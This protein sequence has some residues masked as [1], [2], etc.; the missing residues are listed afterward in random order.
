MACAAEWVAWEAA[1][2]CSSKATE[3]QKTLKN[4]QEKLRYIIQKFDIGDVYKAISNIYNDCNKFPIVDDTYYDEIDS[5]LKNEMLDVIKLMG[6]FNTI[7]SVCNNSHDNKK[8]YM[9][10]KMLINLHDK[11]SYYKIENLNLFDRLIIYLKAN[12]VKKTLYSSVRVVLRKIKSNKLVY[13]ALKLI[14]R[15]IKLIIK[16]IFY[17]PKKIIQFILST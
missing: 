14:K 8:K 4:G 10:R 17:L 13:M 5:K 9:L 3:K 1:L 6:L 16:I 11:Y 2:A 15:I 12:G 7:N